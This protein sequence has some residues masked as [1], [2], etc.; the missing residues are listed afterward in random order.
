MFVLIYVDDILLIGSKSAYIKSLILDVNNQF[1]LKVLKELSF[2]LGIEAH[3]TGGGL[4]LCQAKYTAK[5][6][7]KT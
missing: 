4:Y 1:A 3:K 6:L 2:S 7:V 5:L